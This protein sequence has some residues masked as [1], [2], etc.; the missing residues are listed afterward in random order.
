MEV[1]RVSIVD[2]RV[3]FWRLVAFFIKASFAAI[4]AAI[5]VTLIL[6]LIY[7]GTL[8]WLFGGFGV[9]RI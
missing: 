9:T 8:M 4:P 2:I 5:I 1:G 3:P 6:S 7:Y